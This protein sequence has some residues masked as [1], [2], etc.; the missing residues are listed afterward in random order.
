[1]VYDAQHPGMEGGTIRLLA[2]P[3]R[4]NGERLKGGVAPEL[5]AD[6]EELISRDAA[7]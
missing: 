5:G 2:S 7:E 4:I 3:F 6:T 1:M